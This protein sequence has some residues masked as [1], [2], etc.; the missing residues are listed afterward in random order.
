MLVAFSRAHHVASYQ[1][2]DE[3]RVRKPDG[4]L[5]TSVEYFNTFFFF[6][7]SSDSNI[8]NFLLSSKMMFM[9]MSLPD[10]WEV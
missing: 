10:S 8:L 1:P 7:S 6:F 5:N 3:G 4:M 2:Y 9:Q